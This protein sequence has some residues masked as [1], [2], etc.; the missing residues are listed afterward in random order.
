MSHIRSSIQTSCAY[1]GVGCGVSVSPL[2]EVTPHVN[3]E[4]KN[5]KASAPM[6]NLEGD[7]QHPA[8]KGQLCAKGERLLESLVQPNTLRYPKRKSG[9]PI[10]W[11]VA[12]TTIADTFTKTIA[13]FGP[14]SVAFYLSGQLLTED[15]YVANKLAKGFIGTA[16]VDTNSRLCMSSAVSGHMRAFG[17]DVVPGCY[18][19]FEQADVIV[20]VGANSAWTHPVLFQRMIKAREQSGTK[21]IVVDPAKTATS[22]QADFHLQIT[23]G[24]DSLLFNGL[25][26][27][28]SENEAQDKT[29]ID[30]HTEGFDDVLHTLSSQTDLVKTDQLASSLGLTVSELTQFYQ[31]FIAHEKVIT[32]SC[33]GVNQ[34]T[35]GTDSTNAIIN[36]H[37]AL[38][39]IGKVGCG[40]FSLTGQPNAMGGREVGG[41][42]TQ[43]ACHMGFSAPERQLLADVWQTESIAKD[44]GLTAVELFDAMADGKIKAVWIMGTN[45]LVSLPNT[46]KVQQA[47][48]ACP[49]VV[50]SDIT[51]DAATA[52]QADILLPALGWSEKCGTVTNSERVITRQRGFIPVKGNAKPDWWALAE[53]A[54]RMGYSAAFTFSNS[55]AVFKE[56]AQL[57]KAVKAQ[58]PEKQFDISG[59]SELTDA[60]YDGLAP[61]QWPVT[62]AAM[63]GQTERRLYQGGL[64]STPSTKAQFIATQPLKSEL[65]VGQHQVLLNSG[66]NRDQWHTMTRT[67]HI[68]SLR[69]SIPEPFVAL[70][71]IKIQQLE[72]NDGD[73]VCFATPDAERA[74]V[75]CEQSTSSVQA[76]ARVVAD[77]NQSPDMA[78]MSM[79]WSSQFSLGKGVNQTLNSQLDPISKQP[80]FK[81]QATTVTKVELALQGIIFGEHD[82]L[83]TGTCWNVQQSL[84]AGECYHIAFDDAEKGF[85][86]QSTSYSLKWTVSLLNK[87]VIH[88]QCNMNQGQLVSLK[89]L[90]KQQVEVAL[91]PMHLLIGETVDTGL[92]NRLH[93]LIKAG[94]SPLICACT[95]VTE[96]KI[97]DSMLQA[98]DNLVFAHRTS[99]NEAILSQGDFEQA[100]EQTQSELGC[101]KQCGSCHSEV[102]QCASDIWL[103][104]LEDMA[105]ETVAVKNKKQSKSTQ[106]EVA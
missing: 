41:L 28:I 16:N 82:P 27:F 47:L 2:A 90:S 71:P 75:S 58:F 37:L 17:E 84:S 45:P 34:S 35:S 91:E 29:Y 78:F 55:A 33:Q 50:V 68:A 61:T 104:G 98:L 101:G 6:Y 60:E 38:G 31:L 18:D 100:L 51:Q 44:K 11:D 76:T 83:F 74:Q 66:R 77:D 57:S 7:L 43:L 30:E 1:C 20:L 12:L 102:V 96:A 94:N 69:A 88:V 105:I 106:E 86:F 93:Q 5:S 64:F 14:D 36:C 23:P 9:K 24:T 67:G 13:E 80:G 89:L 54:K 59:M 3:D 95:G 39:H 70:H 8:N 46:A 49:F 97:Q 4:Q 56:F 79:H 10:D 103:L 25:L 87:Q 53:V 22:A 65:S 73:L 72:L 99:G 81:C 32:A 92:M 85:N 40:F 15:Y 48:D 52:K 26:Q 62:S 42:A 19:D 21:I 63:L